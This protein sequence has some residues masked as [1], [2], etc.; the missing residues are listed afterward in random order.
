MKSNAL[1]KICWVGSA[2][3][4][5]P[6]DETSKKK[7]QALSQLGEL[8]VVGV[9]KDIIPRVFR[10]YACFYLLPAVPL[11]LLRYIELYLLTP[12]V[13]LWLVIRHGVSVLVGQ[14]PYEA[15]P[16]ALAKAAA[17]LFGRRVVLIVEN[18]NDF[19][20]T[21]FMQRRIRCQ[22]LFRTL[23]R[24]AAKFTFSQADILRP[25]SNTTRAQVENRCPGKPVFQFVAWTDMEVF[26]QVG[27]SRSDYTS[28]TVVYAGVMIPRKGVLCLVNAFSR[29]LSRVP[30]ARLELVGKAENPAYT[31]AVRET[32]DCLGI[33]DRV[34][35]I[36]ELP[37]KVLA[38]KMGAAAVFVLPSLSEALGR[39]VVEAMATG[40]PAVGS[41]VGGIPEMVIE[42]ETGFLVDP[43]DEKALADKIV[44]I[45]QNPEKA[46]KMGRKAHAFAA[47][48]FSA[49]KFVAWHREMF[50]CAE[51][52]LE[53]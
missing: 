19:E 37:Q 21:L 31:R 2:R 36:P 18:H 40:T 25:V 17:K 53:Q 20:E 24:L 27:R 34:S 52:I 3:Y 43:E 28:K 48:F 44:W 12:V 49:E 51:K 1:S 47:D 6:L 45:L 13:V 26:L 50:A 11:H 46:V 15:V 8:Y 4:S 33:A 29:V 16:A 35:F 9:S 42:G 39:V 23:M 41:R 22:G 32:I 38:G 30:E 14:G 5:D 10:V 7:F